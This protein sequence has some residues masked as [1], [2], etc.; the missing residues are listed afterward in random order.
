MF[1]SMLGITTKDGRHPTAR[2]MTGSMQH[3][4]GVLAIDVNNPA[5]DRTLREVDRIGNK[6]RLAM[7]AAGGRQLTERYAAATAHPN[8][9]K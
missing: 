2:F 5:D 7:K 3:R 1:R 8:H 9:T 6:V 4:D